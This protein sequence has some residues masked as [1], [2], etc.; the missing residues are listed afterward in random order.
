MPT[1]QQTYLTGATAVKIRACVE[2]CSN[3]IK[4][5]IIDTPNLS[6][7]VRAAYSVAQP[8]EIVILSPASASFDCFKNF[9]ERGNAF[10]EF[11]NA[12]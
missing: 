12:L 4:P 10:K 2:E 3:P 6:A 11:V 8:G 7:A 5:D 9:M 1:R